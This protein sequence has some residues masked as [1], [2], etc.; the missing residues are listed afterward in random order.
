MQWDI[1]TRNNF[2][3]YFVFRQRV[4]YNS[5]TVVLE[6]EGWVYV[7]FN[8]PCIESDVLVS[9]TWPDL[10]YWIKDSLTFTSRPVYYD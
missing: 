4:V 5:N 3:D 2:D 6:T 9:Q 1:D 10:N 8:N 7:Q